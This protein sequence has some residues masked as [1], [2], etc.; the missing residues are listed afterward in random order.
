MFHF[1]SKRGETRNSVIWTETPCASLHLVALIH[2][3]IT[4]LTKQFLKLSRRFLG[5]EGNKR[6]KVMF[7]FVYFAFFA[8]MAYLAYILACM[9]FYK[10]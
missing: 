6:K 3:H 10:H 8:Q 5:R 4:A 7:F 2:R 1:F 9:A